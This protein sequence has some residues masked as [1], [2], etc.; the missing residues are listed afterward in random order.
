MDHGEGD[1]AK[2]L[3]IEIR[4]MVQRRVDMPCVLA[5]G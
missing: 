5:D 1:E 3:A 2:E 4:K